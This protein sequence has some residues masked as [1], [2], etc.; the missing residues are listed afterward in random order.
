MKKRIFAVCLLVC[1]LVTGIAFATY[2][3]LCDRDGGDIT[4]GKWEDTGKV[5]RSWVEHEADG[6]YR[7]FE[8]E[9]RRVDHCSNGHFI[10][11]TG[12][13]I[14]KQLQGY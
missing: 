8:K 13:K 9:T 4:P 11:L 2:T 1:L 12:T 10:I 7:Y 3:Y 5:L 14:E 6:Y